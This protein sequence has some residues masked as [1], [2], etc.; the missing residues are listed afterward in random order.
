MECA[1]QLGRTGYLRN[2]LFVYFVLASNGYKYFFS[3]F[4]KAACMNKISGFFEILYLNFCLLKI[5]TKCLVLRIK[6]YFCG[7][8][9]RKLAFERCVLVVG[10]HDALFEDGRRTMLV[11][12]LF[13]TVKQTHSSP[14][15]HSEK[16]ETKRFQ[17]NRR[18]RWPFWKALAQTLDLIRCNLYQPFR[19][20]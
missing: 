19:S 12:K 7:L 20:S 11:D 2:G 8:A 18:A 9:V 5:E 1:Y 14:L 4:F 10:K 13:K 16:W 3:D 6:L 15:V 17:I